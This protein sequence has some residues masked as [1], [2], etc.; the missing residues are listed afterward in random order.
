MEKTVWI[1]QSGRDTRLRRALRQQ[2]N[3]TSI[4]VLAVSHVDLRVDS[5]VHAYLALFRIKVRGHE[6]SDW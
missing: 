5:Q 1:M 6:K 2:F 4:R 3:G